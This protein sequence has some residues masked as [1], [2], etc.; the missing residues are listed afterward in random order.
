MRWIISI[1]RS[2]RS[3]GSYRPF[4]SLIAFKS[5]EFSC[6]VKCSINNRAPC[7]IM[8]KNKALYFHTDCGGRKLTFALLMEALTHFLVYFC[9]CLHL[10]TWVVSGVITFQVT[11]IW[12]AFD[13]LERSV[14][15]S[16]TG[17]WSSWS[18][19]NHLLCC[20]WKDGHAWDW[21][22]TRKLSSARHQS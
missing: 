6:S 4:E 13:V 10:F 11:Q 15:P 17:S 2:W 3:A 19:R 14:S 1:S 20:H 16:W 12:N 5:S 8:S 18:S 9:F 7:M 22:D 21:W